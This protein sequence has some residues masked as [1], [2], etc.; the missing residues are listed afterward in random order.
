MNCPTC[1]SEIEPSGDG[2]LRPGDHTVC[3]Y[4]RVY[5]VIT[6][7]LSFRMLTNREWLVLPVD[8]RRTLSGLRDAL[9]DMTIE[10]KE[11]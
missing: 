8:A 3:V 2:E 9:P 4:C 10:T 7:E 5:L 6:P 1:H 11:K